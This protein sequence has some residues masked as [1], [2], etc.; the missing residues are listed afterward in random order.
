MDVTSAGVDDEFVE[1]FDGRDVHGEAIDK[2]LPSNGVAVM[3]DVDI[4]H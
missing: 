1:T 2:P 4:G 3:P